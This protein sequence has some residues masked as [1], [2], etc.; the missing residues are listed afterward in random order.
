MEL[1]IAGAQIPV[2]SDIEVNL[3]ILTHA[4][5]F[6]GQEEADILLTPEGSLSG[7]TYTFDQE[8]AQEALE[9]ITGLAHEQKIGLALGTYFIEPEDERCS[10]PDVVVVPPL[11]A[12]DGARTVDRHRAAEPRVLS[13][14]DQLGLFPPAAVLKPEDDCGSWFLVGRGPN[15]RQVPD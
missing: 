8:A 1:R 11:G 12:H 5:A 2:T 7:Y 4:I 15:Q 6:A 3:E 9:H 10:R 13:A 14:Y